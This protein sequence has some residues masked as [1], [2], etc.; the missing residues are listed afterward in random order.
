MCLL[1]SVSGVGCGLKVDRYN[2]TIPVSGQGDPACT[3]VGEVFVCAT[4]G[5][6]KPWLSDGDEG[7]QYTWLGTAY[8]DLYIPNSVCVGAIVMN[9]NKPAAQI[10]LPKL[11]IE[12]SVSVSIFSPPTPQGR[13]NTTVTFSQP[14]CG[15]TVRINMTQ[16]ISAQLTLIQEVILLEP[17]I[18]GRLCH[19]LAVQYYIGVVGCMALYLPVSNSRDCGTIIACNNIHWAGNNYCLR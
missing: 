19:N 16:E 14:Y 13:V 11:T 1:T 5:A 2:C 3:V 8:L 9:F 4:G 15:Q 12:P 10:N 17:I 6:V 7:T 18:P